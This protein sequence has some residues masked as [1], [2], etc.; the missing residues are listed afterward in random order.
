MLSAPYASYKV[1]LWIEDS[2]VR[3]RVGA[4]VCHT[5]EGGENTVN[6]YTCVLCLRLVLSAC[7]TQE[8]YCQW[9]LLSTHFALTL[10]GLDGL[11]YYISNMDHFQ[12][13]ATKINTFIC[14]CSG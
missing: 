3:K 13:F 14:L 6:Y 1:R 10:Q 4:L 7:Y 12:S 9:I 8:I 11:T 2:E 5:K